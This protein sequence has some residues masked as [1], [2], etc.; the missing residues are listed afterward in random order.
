MNT[1]P[2]HNPMELPKCATTK[3]SVA[4]MV[5]VCVTPA[6][7]EMH[8]TIQTALDTQSVVVSLRNLLFSEH[9]VKLMDH[10]CVCGSAQFECFFC[11]YIKCKCL[12]VVQWCTCVAVVFILSRLVITK[13]FQPRSRWD[14]DRASFPQTH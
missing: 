9:M 3:E 11:S 1:L 4:Q 13:L 7:A 5:H 14:I 8:V 2:V 10:G 6:T 12:G